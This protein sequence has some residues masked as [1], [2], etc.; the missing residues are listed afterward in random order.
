MYI[1]EPVNTTL[2]TLIELQKIDLIILDLQQKIAEFPNLVQRLDK[3]L[4]DHENR[5][6]TM[7]SR[8]EEQEKSRRT[9]ELEVED[10]VEKIKK[11]QGQLLE[12]KTNKEYSTLL[13]EIKGL[14]TKNSLAEDDIL[15][16]MESI[17]RAKKAITETQREVEK[18][19]VR[20]KQVKQ[21]KEAEQS[22]IQQG[23]A[24]EQE[25]RSQVAA[26]IEEK[27]LKEYSKLL[28]L[29]NGV[30][31]TS[32]EEGG[33]CSGCRVALTP[34]MFAEVKSGDYLHRCPTCFRF[35][36]WSENSEPQ[37]EEA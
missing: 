37:A 18:E 6:L 10:R 35:L 16:L 1:G 31:V 17:D 22:E 24:Q 28:T 15:E 23:L 20:I 26:L 34:Q 8:L 21:E 29:R 13:A 3:Q 30:A 9:K 11:Y 19:K 5:L 7:R 12:V 14:K 33:V 27:I 2:Q 4:T 36:Y 32:V 25:K